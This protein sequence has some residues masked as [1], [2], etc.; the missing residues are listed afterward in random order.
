MMRKGKLSVRTLS[1]F[2]MKLMRAIWWGMVL[3]MVTVVA[4][5]QAPTYRLAPEDVIRVQIYNEAQVAATLT[6]GAD[7]NITAPFV[8]IIRA[9][10]KTTTELEADLAREYTRRLRLR[11]PIVSVTIERYRPIRVAIGGQVKGPGIYEMRAGDTVLTLLYRGGGVVEDGSA[12]MRRATFRRKNSQELIPI[13]I[14]SMLTRGNLAQNY[15]LEDGDELVVPQETRNRVLVMGTVRSPQ[16][17]PYKEPMTL[18]DALS[19]SGGPVP[20]RSWLSRTMVLRE[21]AGLPG[22][23]VRIEA[24]LVRFLKE[25]DA[26][27]N[28]LLRPGDIVIVP[29]TKTPDVDVLSTYTSALANS[30]F[31]LDRFGLNFFRR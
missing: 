21:R 8:G 4:Q 31:I 18:A 7:G 29:D 15:T 16:T 9:E 28:I 22:N 17:L 11:D 6:V 30:I 24:N 20:L 27:Q 13:D 23:Y 12:D 3:L 2:P 19:L 14:Y 1:G 10:G 26:S 25:G 5:A